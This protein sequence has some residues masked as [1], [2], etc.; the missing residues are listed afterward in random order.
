MATCF[1]GT[2]GDTAFE[3]WCTP[4]A[5]LQGFEGLENSALVTHNY[6]DS[7]WSYLVR[8]SVYLWRLTDLHGVPSAEQ[9]HGAVSLADRK[10]SHY[11]STLRSCKRQVTQIS[12]ATKF[13]Q[14]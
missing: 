9:N 4:L 11:I 6:R 3:A 5:V 14:H 1:S 13:I 7:W 10:S 8:T 2:A 12:T